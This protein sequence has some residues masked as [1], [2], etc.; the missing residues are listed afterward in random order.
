MRVFGLSKWLFCLLKNGLTRKIG[1]DFFRLA[2]MAETDCIAI[3]IYDNCG[4]ADVQGLRGM[5]GSAGLCGLF[6]TH[7]IQKNET[8]TY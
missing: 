4:T 3:F 6:F 2:L 8:G 7:S 5:K 1:V